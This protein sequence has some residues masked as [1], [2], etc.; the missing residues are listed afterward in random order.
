MELQSNTSERGLSMAIEFEIYY[1][2]FI[3]VI[4]FLIFSLIWTIFGLLYPLVFVWGIITS[5]KNIDKMIEDVN[6]RESA[7]RKLRGKDPLS[8]ID[9]GY[10]NNVSDSGLVYASGVFGPCLLYTSPSPRDRQK[11]RMPS[12][13]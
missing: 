8:T 12:S 1:I 7:T 11:S 5:G 6:R 9:G 2:L 10:R 13:A 3:L 4:P